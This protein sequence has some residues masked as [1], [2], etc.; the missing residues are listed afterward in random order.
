MLQKKIKQGSP[1]F[2][3]EFGGLLFLFDSEQTRNLFLRNPVFFCNWENFW[4]FR[5]NRRNCEK[6]LNIDKK[7]NIL[8]LGEDNA[9]RKCMINFLSQKYKLKVIDPKMILEEKLKTEFCEE[10]E[11]P[12]T[13]T[14]NN[15][16]FWEHGCGFSKKNITD[17][18]QGKE[19]EA[20]AA[21][22]VAFEAMGLD[23]TLKPDQLPKDLE[24]TNEELSARLV[25]IKG[26]KSKKVREDPVDF[27]VESFIPKRAE[28]IELLKLLGIEEEKVEN[29]E[30]NEEG[31][32]ESVIKKREDKKEEERELR[33]KQRVEWEKRAGRKWGELTGFLFVDFPKKAEDVDLLKKLGIE[34]DRVILLDEEDMEEEEELLPENM[35]ELHHLRNQVVNYLLL[36]KNMEK[37]SRN[38]FIGKVLF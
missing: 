36:D 29:E 4:L 16:M 30:E 9:R 6:Q 26:K 19:I 2:A 3:A 18:G 17:L 21:M 15:P 25:K 23:I 11:K 31:L 12:I 28:T 27:G 38:I 10:W 34:F 37:I 22:T 7:V 33:E 14:I 24:F 8:V 13:N 32:T 5:T 35:R 1:Q 20:N